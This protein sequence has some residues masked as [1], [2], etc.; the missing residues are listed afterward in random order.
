VVEY[1]DVEEAKRRTG[2]RLVL[3]K[4][5]PGPWGEAAKAILHVKGIP[6]VPVRQDG[7][8]ENRALLEWT[9]QTSAPVAVW[10]DEPPR[11]TSREILFLAERLAPEPA[12]LPEDAAERA[13]VQGLADEIHGE[14]GFGWSRRLVFVH[15]I[16]E[17]ANRE[18]PAVADV[19][20]MAAKYGYDGPTAVRARARSIGIVRM[21]AGRLE[22]QQAAGRR[23]LVGE[24]LSAADLYWA[25]FA[26]LIEPMPHELCPMPDFLRTMYTTRDEELR[27]PAASLLAHRDAIYREFLE[28]PMAF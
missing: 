2:L 7:G 25:A 28:L 22:A 4:G 20:R 8:G 15:S 1:I 5:V 14:M 9:G 6:Y 3:T 13:L 19:A 18:E 24:R 12:L 27:A 10:N 11:S 17:H 16:L 23:F 26:A 21:L